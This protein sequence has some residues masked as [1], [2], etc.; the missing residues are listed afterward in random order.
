VK[1]CG[2]REFYLHE[3]VDTSDQ[4]GSDEVSRWLGLELPEFLATITGEAGLAARMRLLPRGQERYYAHTD[5]SYLG[6]H[7]VGLRDDGWTVY[8]GQS[9]CC[10]TFITVILWVVKA[11]WDGRTKLVRDIPCPKADFPRGSVQEDVLMDLE[12]RW[13]R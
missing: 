11:R 8:V 1:G 12:A 3:L 10:G 4:P 9:R 7:I 6:V 2:V 13:C 5:L